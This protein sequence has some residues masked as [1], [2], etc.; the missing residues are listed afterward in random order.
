MFDFFNITLKFYHYIAI[1]ASTAMLLFLV[2]NTFFL[3]NRDSYEILLVNFIENGDTLGRFGDSYY[4]TFYNRYFIGLIYQIFGGNLSVIWITQLFI[5]LL[6]GYLMYLILK[7]LFSKK[8]HIT[9]EIS[10]SRSEIYA[11][12]GMVLYIFN[13]IS[14]F[15]ITTI[16][17]NLI[18]I[19]VS[20]LL[21]NALVQKQKTLV[22]IILQTLLIAIRIEY[23]LFIIPIFYYFKREKTYL[24]NS[25]TSATIVYSLF[26]ISLFSQGWLERQLEIVDLVT[27]HLYF[28]AFLLIFLLIIWKFFYKYLIKAVLLA[29][30]GIVPFIIVDPIEL[31]LLPQFILLFLGPIIFGI[32]LLFQFSYRNQTPKF[33]KFTKFLVLSASLFF[34]FYQSFYFQ[35]L[36]I[37]YPLLLIILFLTLYQNLKIQNSIVILL[38]SLISTLQLFTFYITLQPINLDIQQKVMNIVNPYLEDNKLIN[39]NTVIISQFPEAVYFHNPNISSMSFNSELIIDNDLTYI[40]LSINNDLP[41]GLDNRDLKF[42][43]EYSIQLNYDVYEEWFNGSPETLTIYTL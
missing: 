2:N 30:S 14:I 3:I 31:N 15:L 9:Q 21:I 23:F 20:L 35:H 10:A 28:W 34:I 25:I 37:L 32:F 6:S 11:I 36:S 1:I 16:S 39:E 24:L 29:I 22:I 4:V 5:H 17:S 8:K 42:L 33:S 18:T 27:N 43:K 13:P 41:E 19:L 40:I 12:L 7:A 26:F 38:I